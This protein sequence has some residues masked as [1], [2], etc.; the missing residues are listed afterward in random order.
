MA[1]TQNFGWPI[2]EPTSST[3]L[4]THFKA[5]G[6]AID[7]TVK[8]L[9]VP[10]SWTPVLYAPTALT[11]G[12]G[13]LIGRTTTVGGWTFDSVILVRGADTNK[14][15][16]NYQ[17]SM[18]RNAVQWQMPQGSGILYQADG[19]NHPLSIMGV[20]SGRV[21]LALTT[22]GARIA[23]KRP[24]GT[25]WVTGDTIAFSVMYQAA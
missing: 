1:T 6:D 20:G 7:S 15:S 9:T 16:E 4:W 19:N 3:E 8:G 21:G 14:G 24:N 12:S 13:K 11:I 23:G 17:F 10:S 5:L 25:D 18:S 2:P 22:T